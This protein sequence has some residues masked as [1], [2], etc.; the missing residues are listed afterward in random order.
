[1]KK[2]LILAPFC[3]LPGEPSFN[4]FLYLAEL[5]SEKYKVTLLTSNFRHI[6]KVNRNIVSSSRFEIV[7]LDEPGYKS[8]VSIQRLYSHYIFCKNLEQWLSKNF[9]FE[10]V[11]S[12]FPLIESNIKV[13]KALKG[14]KF[15]VDVQDVWPE[16]IASVFPFIDK[17]PLNFL[18]FTRKSNK[19]YSS[20]DALVAVSQTYLDR[21]LLVNSTKNAEVVYIG[22]DFKK[23]QESL[24]EISP[25]PEIF[26][27]VYIG[28]LSFSYDVET[29]ITSI[30]EL[31]AEGLNIE[32]HI[33]GSG[34][35]ENKLKNKNANKVY[36]H[37]FT[38]FSQMISFMK[39]CD[40]GV[41]C[42]T[43]GAKQSVTNKLSDFLSLGIPTLNSQVNNE[44]LDLLKS[45]ETENYT[46]L[47]VSSCKKA[48]SALYA[49]RHELEFKPNLDF[50]RE[51]GYKKILELVSYQLQ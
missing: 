20:A 10:L 9:D 13:I 26:K 40:V 2:I 29:V 39:S 48:I 21:A 12:A 44:V 35:F 31:V 27:L 24:P 34:P 41:N 22:S 42:L 50:D 23:I 18:P 43:K 30:N 36:F 32:F 17:I 45:I 28:T 3:S 38:P 1:M 8:N 49:R 46:P 19:V 25:N 11:Y 51:T 6:D 33:F 7:M 5:L 14:A 4:R 37:G 15:I 47:S 16:S